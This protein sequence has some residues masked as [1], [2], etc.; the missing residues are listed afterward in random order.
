MKIKRLLLVAPAAVLA[1]HLTLS[2]T[3]FCYSEMRFFSDAELIQRVLEQRL[4]RDRAGNLAL[5]QALDAQPDCCTVHRLFNARVP[6]NGLLDKFGRVLV[7]FNI[8]TVRL[9]FGPPPP[10]ETW[11]EDLLIVSSCGCVQD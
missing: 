11:D 3:G 6:N 2:A 10:G 7:G 8:A 1:A 9:D 5:R 4:P